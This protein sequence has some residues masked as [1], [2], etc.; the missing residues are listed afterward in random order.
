MVT[1]IPAGKRECALK[2]QSLSAG[3]PALSGNGEIVVAV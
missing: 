1:V 2:W 3:H